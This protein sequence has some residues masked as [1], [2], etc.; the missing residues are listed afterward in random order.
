M[1]K[2]RDVT[3]KDEKILDRWGIVI[4]NAQG[5]M[6]ELYQD[7]Q[8]FIT[9]SEA[10]GVEVELVLAKPDMGMVE[11]MVKGTGARGYLMIT[12]QWLK[13]YHMYV[14]ARDYG[15][16][17]DVQWYLSCEPGFLSRSF[18][19]AIT[20]G[21]SDNAWSFNLDLFQQQDLSAYTTVM[22]HCLLKAVEKLMSRLGQDISSI[23][24][25][26]K[27]FLGVS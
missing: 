5:N 24:R 21:S 6:D 25:K 10:P 18:S 20:K 1:A 4:E 3:L 14:G 15:K 11:R 26:S 2:S 22:H 19:Q 8:G 17:L 23:D 27:G 7:T 16:N 13:D 12:N 9:A